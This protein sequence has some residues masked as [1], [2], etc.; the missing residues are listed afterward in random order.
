GTLTLTGT[1]TASL[2]DPSNWTVSMAASRTI[3]AS[4]AGIVLDGA[5]DQTAALQTILDL[6]GSTSTPLHLVIDGPVMLYG[7]LYLYSHQWLDG[8]EGGQLLRAPYP[9]NNGLNMVQNKNPVLG[10]V[11][12]PTDQYIKITNLYMDGNRRNG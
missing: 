12:S 7:T 10:S 3:Y 2:T 1:N 8:G 9:T 5:T 4:T 11:G 6:Y